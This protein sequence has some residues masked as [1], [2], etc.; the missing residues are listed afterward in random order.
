MLGGDGMGLMGVQCKLFE[1]EMMSV[2][3]DGGNGLQMRLIRSVCLNTITEAR[4]E[5]LTATDSDQKYPQSIH[6]IIRNT[7][8]PRLNFAS[9]LGLIPF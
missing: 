4:L 6:V 9:F 3:F 5:L 2:Y 7:I 8:Q 1:M